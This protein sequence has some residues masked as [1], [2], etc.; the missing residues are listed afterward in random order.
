MRVNAVGWQRTAP[1]PDTYVPNPHSVSDPLGLKPVDESDP[2]WGGRVKYKGLDRLG[3]AKGVEALLTPSMTGGTTNP[4]ID[5]AGWVSNG[6]FN[7][8]HLLGAQ[9]GGSNKDPRNFVTMHR[10]ANSPVMRDLETQVRKAVDKGE[11]I[12]YRVTPHYDGRDL[13]PKGVTIEAYGNKGFKFKP[14]GSVSGT[15][16]L[17]ICNKKK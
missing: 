8:A 9:L 17:S 2:T 5:P 6:L 10:Y 14:K 16:I 12:R 13:L 3:R 15:N 11:T 4:R 7:R 1:N